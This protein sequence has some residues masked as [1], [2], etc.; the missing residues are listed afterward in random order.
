MMKNII[1]EP[2]HLSI[3]E[4]TGIG[5]ILLISFIVNRNNIYG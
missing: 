3:K 5:I 2:Q 1:I 4:L